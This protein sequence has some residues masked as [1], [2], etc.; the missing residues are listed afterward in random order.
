MKLGDGGGVLRGGSCEVAVSPARES[1]E[2]RRRAATQV[3]I[4]CAEARSTFAVGDRR[5]EITVEQRDRGP[6][7]R[8]LRG[9]TGELGVVVHDQLVGGSVRFE[10]GFDAVQE[11]LDAGRV[12]HDHAGTDPGDVEHR[13][14]PEHLLG[15]GVEPLLLGGILTGLTELWDT[16]LDQLGGLG[17]VPSRRRVTDRLGPVAGCLEPGAGA[18]VE[19]GDAVGVLVFEAGPQDVAE[20]VVIPVP[21]TAVVEGNEEEVRPLQHFEDR[22]GVAAA[23]DSGAQLGAEPAQDRGLQEEGPH[24]VGLAVEHFVGEIVDDEPVVTGEG[25]DERGTVVPALEG[26]SSELK[27]GDPAFRSAFEGVDVAVSQVEAH[28]IVQV[29]GCLFGT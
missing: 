12:A 27:R 24:V 5:G 18:P 11:R 3:V 6:V 14:V 21:A 25:L 4:G 10:P 19:L 23:S 16:E 9:E 20:E 15:Q 26:E 8:R 29:G 7:H 22:L 1:D 2:G 17:V 13:A 28:G